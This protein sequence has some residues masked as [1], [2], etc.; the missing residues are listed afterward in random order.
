[1][2][3]LGRVVLELVLKVTVVLQVIALAALAVASAS[4]VCIGKSVVHSD[5]RHVGASEHSL[6]LF[7]AASTSSAFVTEPRLRYVAQGK[8]GNFHIVNIAVTRSGKVG[9]IRLVRRRIRTSFIVRTFLKPGTMRLAGIPI[10]SIPATF[11]RST[12]VRRA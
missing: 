6:F 4:N 2:G 12:D 3:R 11:R 1:M 8:G 10:T 9:K 7:V 5:R